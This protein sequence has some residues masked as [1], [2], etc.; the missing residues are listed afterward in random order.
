[1]FTSIYDGA[2]SRCNLPPNPA[3]SAASCSRSHARNVRISV[4]CARSGCTGPATSPPILS[5]GDLFRAPPRPERRPKSPDVQ[6]IGRMLSAAMEEPTSRQR[7]SWP[8]R[9]AA[10]VRF[11]ATTRARAEE[12]CGVT[13]GELD[14][15]AERPIWR[16]GRSKGG[17]SRDVPLPWAT[18]K[19]I[20]D[21]LAERV[22]PGQRRR[23]LKARRADPLFVRPMEHRCPPRPS[24]GWYGGLRIVPAWSF[25]KERPPTP[26]ATTTASPWPC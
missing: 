1:M 22:E 13:I 14:R 16:V 20:D 2:R 19:A 18:V 12:A 26:S 10:L 3:W 15:R 25:P 6:D 17:K 23:A 24:T 8:T 5:T 21:W 9:D 11:L 7:M 4:A